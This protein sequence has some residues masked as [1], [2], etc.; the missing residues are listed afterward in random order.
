MTKQ[1][2]NSWNC[3]PKNTFLV[4]T[5]YAQPVK[6]YNKYKRLNTV[7]DVRKVISHHLTWFYSVMW[8]NSKDVFTDSEQINVPKKC[9]Y[10]KSF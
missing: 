9:F 5:K 2:W 4:R 8:E 7:T 6:N 3:R 1:A 10:Y